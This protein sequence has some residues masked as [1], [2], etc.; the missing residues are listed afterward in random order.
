L[1]KDAAR[2]FKTP[3]FFV[4][5]IVA[6]AVVSVFFTAGLYADGIQTF[7]N[8]NAT[9]YSQDGSV[10][11][12][13]AYMSPQAS[14]SSGASLPSYFSSQS[15]SSMVLEESLGLSRDQ[16]LGFSVGGAKDIDNFR[17]NIE[18][19]FLPLVTD[20]THEGLF[21]DYYFDT[22]VVE[23]C[24]K[25]FCPSYSYAISPDPLSGENQYYL[26]VGLNSGIKESDFERKKL[27]L[28]IVL[29]VSGSM[30]SPFNQYHYDHFG[31]RHTMYEQNSFDN[32]KTKMQLAS[33]S[34]SGLLDHLNDDDRLGI[35][36][37]NNGAH[38]SKPLE[39]MAI[40]D[41]ATLKGEI[42]EIV[43]SGG[44]NMAAG[45]IM[46][47]SLFDED[48]DYDAS[49]YENRIIFL[50]D[51]MPNLGDI[52]EN[53]L[54]GMLKKNSENKIYTTFIGIGIDLNTELVEKITKNRGANYY[55]V[56][57]ASDF[58]KTNGR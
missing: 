18:G 6:I 31:N 42:M 53:G 50:T 37:F 29:D 22:G 52:S 34:V 27:N 5:G 28:V 17:K 56:H 33:E 43:A 49:E 4:L 45:M 12:G 54:H 8:K 39:S 40:T 3:S 57:S 9:W 38:L 7:Q 19:G 36:L 47:T 2:F 25:L 46:G 10:R 48:F 30:S 58:K 55:S 13:S 14:S 26:S 21:Y 20:I 32:S 44:T 24:Q 23:E 51:A 35:V 16:R 11:E 41:K 15:G 1:H